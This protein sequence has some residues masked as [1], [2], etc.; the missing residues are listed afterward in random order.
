[1]SLVATG[2]ICGRVSGALCSTLC[3]G[4]EFMAF[5]ESHP[6]CFSIEKHAITLSAKTHQVSTLLKKSDK[7]GALA[8]AKRIRRKEKD[9]ARGDL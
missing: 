9:I 1:M 7:F 6:H 3:K 5:I 2:E 8:R 4:A